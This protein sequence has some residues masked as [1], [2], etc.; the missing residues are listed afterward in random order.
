MDITLTFG[1]ATIDVSLTGGGSLYVIHIGQISDVAPHDIQY[2]TDA[3][4]R[5]DFT[6]VSITMTEGP[7]VKLDIRDITSPVYAT[8]QDLYD[9]VRDAIDAL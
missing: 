3:A 1:P 6:G 8:P 7:Q 9:A 2:D 4:S 5:E